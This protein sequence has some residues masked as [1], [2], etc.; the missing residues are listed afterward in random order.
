[1]TAAGNPA[2]DD[3]SAGRFEQLL[4]EVRGRINKRQYDTWFTRMSLKQWSEGQ[5]V[6]AVPN[7][8]HQEWSQTKFTRLLREAALAVTPTPVKVSFEI[9]PESLATAEAAPRAEDAL[10]EASLPA[11]DGVRPAPAGTYPAPFQGSGVGDLPLRLNEL[12]TFDNYIVGPANSVAHASARAVG[13]N[14]GRAYNP[15]FIH[16]SVG[17]GKTHLLH[18]VCHEFLARFAGDRICFLSCE[19]FT[20]EF[21]RSL[22]RNEVDR[23]RARFRNVHLLVI[24]DIHFLK[25]KERTQEEFFHTFNQLYQSNRQIVLSSDAA[26]GEIPT[27]EDRLVSRFGWGLVTQLEQPEMETRMAIIRRK[28]ELMP[29]DVPNDV[30]EFIASHFRNNIRELEGALL[31]TRAYADVLGEPVSLRVARAALKQSLQPVG[32]GITIDRIAQ[33]VCAQYDVKLTDLRSKRRGRSVSEPR[34]VIMFLARRLTPLS[35]DEIGGAFGGRDHSTVLYGVRKVEKRYDH[36]PAFA[37]SLERFADRLGGRL[38][39]EVGL[40]SPQP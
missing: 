6:L 22:Q 20:N 38:T 13:Q 4:T 10:G 27:L 12:Y 7:R 25:G 35:L 26:P 15:L 31:G 2:Y 34:Q 1:M 30:V 9:D 24:D 5:L 39:P 40:Q 8:F 14:P 21:V 17:L 23:F 16:G 18:A 29:I 19:E 11:T 36:D 37:A 3:S 32:A 28:A 33:L